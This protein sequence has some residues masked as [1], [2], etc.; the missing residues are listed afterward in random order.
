MSKPKVCSIH[1]VDF[2]AVA[3]SLPKIEPHVPRSNELIDIL[4][5][6]RGFEERV[7]EVPRRLAQAK[8]I[9]SRTF[10][11]C[12][13]YAT[14]QTDNDNRFTEL[15]QWLAGTTIIDCDA[16][17]PSNTEQ[18]IAALLSRCP[19]SRA[20]RVVFDISGSSSTFIFSVM[21]AL[22]RSS[23]P[24]ELEVVYAEADRY[25]PDVQALEG[26]SFELRH[27]AS[28]ASGRPREEGA[29]SAE[30]H[31]SYRGLQVENRPSHIIGVPCLSTG[32][33]ERCLQQLGEE[34]SADPS[35]ALTLILP[36]TDADAH[37]WREGAIEELART[38]TANRTDDA[39]KLPHVERCDT[40]VYVQI[41]GVI[42]RLAD[43]HLGSNVYLVHF[44]P[45]LQTIGASLALLAREEIA[46]MFTRPRKFFADRYSE[47]VGQ[48]WS[49]RIGD[50]RKL[51]GD[52]RNVGCLQVRWDEA[53]PGE[54]LPTHS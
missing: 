22:R 29:G 54:Y 18:Q 16:D 15:V 33:F 48:V 45:K 9:D 37:N 26:E 12:G 6:A 35:E 42:L 30:F 20:H 39:T 4:I 49:L 32:R 51:V 23:T 38:F 8:A 1:R 52:L 17:S 44:G 46:L 21:A 36:Y 25:Y 28:F 2:A 50:L 5:L 31:E 53:A 27:N 24:V 40:H 14:N 34:D 10:V 47:G 13:R 7:V 11:M 3:E 19:R 41:L 43:T